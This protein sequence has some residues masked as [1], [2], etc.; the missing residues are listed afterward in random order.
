MP[1]SIPFRC[2]RCGQPYVTARC[3][4]CYPAKSKARSSDGRRSSGRRSRRVAHPDI[5]RILGINVDAIPDGI[6]G[7]GDATKTG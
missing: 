2:H 3:P 5:G 7:V 1:R 6:E 4:S